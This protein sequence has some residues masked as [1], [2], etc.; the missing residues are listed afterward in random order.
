MENTGKK[1]VLQIAVIQMDM[2]LNQGEANYAHA[3]KL[4]RDAMA[5]SPRPDVLVFPETW[6]LGFSPAVI[7]QSQADLDGKKTTAFFSALA[8]ENEV[9]IVGG[10][11]VNKKGSA[12]YNSAFV[13]NRTGECIASYDKTHL[14]SPM[15]EDKVFS[16]GS[17]LCTF[18]VDGFSA[19][20]V[21]CYD[22]RFPELTRTMTLGGIDILFVVSQ[23]PQA[24]KDHLRVLTRARAIENQMFLA[25]C[26]SCGT[27]GEVKY[28]GQS[29]V[30]DPWGNVISEAGTEEQIFCAGC[31]G[32]ILEG[33]R[34]SIPVFADRNP[35]LY[36]TD[37]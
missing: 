24:R 3:G 1:N 10:S 13:F 5:L 4:V 30:I 18:K 14:F 8:R 35:S 6:N 2:V 22:I 15:G 33:I 32:S 23:W 17:S 25:L 31:D 7:D 16:K 20:L 19:A 28:A 29:A 37:K 12:L 11:V 36:H 34:N 27:A 26:N 9:N 21:I